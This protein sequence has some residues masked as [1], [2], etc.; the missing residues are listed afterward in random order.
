MTSTTARGRRLLVVSTGGAGPSDDDQTRRLV[1]AD[2]QPDPLLAGDAFDAT[3][4]NERDLAAVAGRRGRVLRRLPTPVG[5]AFE[6]W[7]RRREPG[8]ARDGSRG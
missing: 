8:P 2:A 3:A 6:V 1:A 5:L 7:R 4:L